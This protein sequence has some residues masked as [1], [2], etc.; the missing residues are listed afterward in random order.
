[1]LCVS[2]RAQICEP[3]FR[4]LARQHDSLSSCANCCAYRLAHIIGLGFLFLGS[5]GDVDIDPW[6]DVHFACTRERTAGF[7]LNIIGGQPLAWEILKTGFSKVLDLV[8][9]REDLLG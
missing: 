2:S 4:I 7:S 9:H 8:R 1:T 5:G 3:H 6:P